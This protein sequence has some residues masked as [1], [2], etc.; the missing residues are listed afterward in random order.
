MN[1]N[2]LS[3][4]FS[5]FKDKYIQHTSENKAGDKRLPSR[6]PALPQAPTSPSLPLY[7]HLRFSWERLP[8]P[9]TV[10]PR[11]TGTRTAHPMERLQ[12]R[13]LKILRV[14]Q[15]SSAPSLPVPAAYR[16]AALAPSKCPSHYSAWL[17]PLPPL[18][19]QKGDVFKYGYCK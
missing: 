16:T 15:P 17:V 1:E 2:K 11:R 13:R 7:L 12:R 3:E 10:A 8:S 6:F 19:V 14:S 9:C 18:Q 5:F 4:I